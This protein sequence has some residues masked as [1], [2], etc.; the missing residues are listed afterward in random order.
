[1]PSFLCSIL[2]STTLYYIVKDFVAPEITD[3]RSGAP[4]TI[5]SLS[6]SLARAAHPELAA[7]FG[8]QITPGRSLQIDRQRSALHSLRHQSNFKTPLRN[9]IVFLFN[10]LAGN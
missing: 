8:G 6:R 9:H 1:V 7:T 4:S 10:P 2:D 5:C 3:T